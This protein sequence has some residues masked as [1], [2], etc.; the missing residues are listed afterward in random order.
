LAIA[1]L[2][3]LSHRQEKR[4]DHDEAVIAQR[5]SGDVAVPRLK[6]EPILRGC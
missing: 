3:V 4:R 6:L 2:R 5:E 1:P